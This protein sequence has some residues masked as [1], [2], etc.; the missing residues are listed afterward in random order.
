MLHFLISVGLADVFVLLAFGAP[1]NPFVFFLD[2][3]VS[4]IHSFFLD[5]FVFLGASKHSAIKHIKNTPTLEVRAV[6]QP[7][8]GKGSIEPLRVGYFVCNS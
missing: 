3:F 7:L 2:P 8:R 1:T 4:R 6:A 5:P